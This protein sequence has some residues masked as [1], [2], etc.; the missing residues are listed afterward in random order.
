METIQ[1]FERASGRRVPHK[2]VTRQ[3]GDV[4]TYY[5]DT[6]KAGKLMNWRAVRTLEE[7][8]AST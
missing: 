1:A 2:L 6:Q 8:C 4:A 7:S 3:T 5:V